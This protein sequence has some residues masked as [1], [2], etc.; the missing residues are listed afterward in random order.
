MDNACVMKIQDEEDK[1]LNSVTNRLNEF[2]LQMDG[3]QKQQAEFFKRLENA[4]RLYP[5][6][7]KT[8]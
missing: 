4:P 3:M 5:S 2:Q 6:N 8:S 7:Q 1:E